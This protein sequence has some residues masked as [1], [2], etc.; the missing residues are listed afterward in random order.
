VRK[1]ISTGTCAAAA[2]RAAAMLIIGGEP[3]A[4]VRVE[5]P[6][7]E[8]VTVLVA[9]QGLEADRA[10]AMVRKDAGDD[11]DVTHGLFIGANVRLAGQGITIT[12]GRGV[13]RVTRPGLAVSPGS[14]AIN[15]V[16][17]AMIRA[18]VSGLTDRGLEVEIFVPGGEKI[19]AKTFNRRLGIVGGI[20]IL[21]TSGI[22]RP[23]SVEAIR[24]TIF[25]NIKMVLETGRDSLVLVP[26]RLGFRAAR[27]H[28]FARDEIVEVSNEWRFALESCLELNLR[29]LVLAGHPGKLL[30][31]IDGDFQTHS[32]KSSSAVPVFQRLAGECLGREI[33]GLNTVEEGINGLGPGERSRAGNYMARLVRDAVMNK[34][35][36]RARI[37]VMLINLKGEIF[38]H[39]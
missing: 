32:N 2:A 11:P 16:P 18:A 6:S 17:M 26:G 27:E 19:A 10:W 21:G 12:G 36:Q 9:E 39:A 23:F 24:E 3:G 31:F 25:L 1:G 30:K 38:G 4:A 35:Q 8:F 7:K 5:L 29:R 33:R 15:P 20:S 13:G 28:G 22:V 37:K 14:P 34:T